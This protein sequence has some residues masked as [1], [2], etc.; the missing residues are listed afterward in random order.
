M[1]MTKAEVERRVDIR[2]SAC[3]ARYWET[4]Q[5]SM[6]YKEITAADLRQYPF[7][8]FG[9]T[10]MVQSFIGQILPQDI[11]KRVYL[12]GEILQVEN[13]DQRAAR[14]AKANA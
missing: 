6:G 12:V 7:R 1:M 2:C 3:L 8:A 5:V 14:L 10:W 4:R 9:R 11:G 13:D